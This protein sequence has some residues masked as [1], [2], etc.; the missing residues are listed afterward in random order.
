MSE[1]S[2]DMALDALVAATSKIAPTLSMDI[3]RQA[4]AI[5][6][7]HQF[8]SAPDI[9]LRS[10]QKLIEDLVATGATS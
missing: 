6:R 2:E 7:D 10:L 3:V 1:N 5:E 4:Y 9:R 8:D